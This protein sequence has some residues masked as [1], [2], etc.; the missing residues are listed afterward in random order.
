MDDPTIL[1]IGRKMEVIDRLSNELAQSGLKVFGATDEP[2]IKDVLSEHKIDLIVVGAGLADEVRN[3]LST[4]VSDTSNI[5]VHLIERTDKSN[6]NMMI[7]FT[8]A[9]VKEWKSSN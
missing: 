2:S 3:A 1:M 4:S 8:L 5:P 6:P 7:D 9:K